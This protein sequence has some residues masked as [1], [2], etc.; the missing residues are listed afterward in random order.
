MAALAEGAGKEMPG[1]VVSV[2]DS[3]AS[4][5]ALAWAVTH[6]ALE[7]A[8]LTVLAVH[9]VAASAW[10]GNPIIY[11]EDRAE[12]EKVLNAAE[13]TVSEKIGELG[14]ERPSAVTVR[15]SIGQ[16]GDALIEASHDA[17]MV[18]LGTSGSGF[19]RLMPRSV[20]ARVVNR[21]AC[22]VVV[23]SGQR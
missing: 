5:D 3:A 16:L 13:K 6:A 15:G 12:A 19:A 20:R 23:I 1:I 2:D 17:D 22:P 18:V 10:T 8:P 14:D 11:P 7:H 21:A 4:Q 9:R